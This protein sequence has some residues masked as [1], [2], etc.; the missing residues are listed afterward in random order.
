M[1]TV[2]SITSS[3]VQPAAGRI[4]FGFSGARATCVS[5]SGSG[6]PTA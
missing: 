1:N 3:N 5:S 6:L 2:T 4:A